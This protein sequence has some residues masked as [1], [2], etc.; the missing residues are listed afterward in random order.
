MSAKKLCLCYFDHG[1]NIYTPLDLGYAKAFITKENPEADVQILKINVDRDPEVFEKEVYYL[2]SFEADDFIFFIDNVL[3]SA[4][5]YWEATLLLAEKLKKLK[6]DVQIGVQS[7]KIKDSLAEE[8]LTAHPEIDYLLRGEPEIPLGEYVKKGDFE[9]IPGFVF[10]KNKNIQINEEAPLEKNLDILPSP[11]LSGTLDDFIAEYP[12]RSYF[13][14]TSRGCPFRCHYCF[15]S[16]KFSE[17]RT[18]SI[19]RVLDEIEYLADKNIGNIFMLDD[20]FIVSHDRFFEMVEAYE[21][22]FK[23]RKNLPEINIMCRPEFLNEKV[24]EALP[25]M[26]IVFV[27]L[28]L[29]SI[30][31]KTDKIMG[32]GVDMDRFQDIITQL[33]KQKIKVHLDVIIGLPG[34]DLDHCKRTMDF[35][36]GLKPWSIQI[37]QLYQNPNTLFD[38]EPEKYGIKV[39]DQDH[40]FHVPF[41]TENNT[42]TNEDMKTASDYAKGLQQ[43]NPK[44]RMRI[45]TQFYRFSNYESQ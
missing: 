5:Y 35:A 32:R 2:A 16:V 40:L 14:S 3:W 41:V 28:G 39:E 43:K 31:P 42:F 17:V 19:D 34:D 23:N 15:R 26:N 20:C 36:F 30:N 11:Y 4:M 12:Y 10:R 33:Q 13:I 18:F 45:V 1:N 9:K 38:L 8:F 37:K 25:R 21:K 22:R 6:P 24:I 27:Q 7:Y 29:Q 44:M